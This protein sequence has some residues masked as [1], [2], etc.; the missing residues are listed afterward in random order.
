MSVAEKKRPR[1]RAAK[2]TLIRMVGATSEQAAGLG[3]RPELREAAEDNYILPV[4]MQRAK[5]QSPL[6]FDRTGGGMQPPG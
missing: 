1:T 4:A 2:H 6:N 3:E 5:L